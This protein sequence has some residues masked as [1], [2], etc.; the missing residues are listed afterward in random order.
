[1]RDR[2]LRAIN[3]QQAA[4]LLEALRRASPL[5]HAQSPSPTAWG[6]PN[7][8]DPFD[9]APQPPDEHHYDKARKQALEAIA[10]LTELAGIDPDQDSKG[11]HDALQAALGILA[12]LAKTIGADWPE[13]D[14]QD[15]EPD[16]EPAPRISPPR[17]VTTED[18]Y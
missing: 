1:M 4:R 13:A 15:R 11:C 7:A 2:D 12:D 5:D 9:P 17:P 8:T 6:D 14:I 18:D 16:L 10:K 3:D